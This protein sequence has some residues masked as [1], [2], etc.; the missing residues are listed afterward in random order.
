MTQASSTTE[1]RIWRRE[2]PSV[3]SIANSRVRWATVIENVLKIRNAATNRATP[4]KTSSAVFR[5]PRT[6]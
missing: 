2:A 1:H 4:A 5:K 6:R 3:R